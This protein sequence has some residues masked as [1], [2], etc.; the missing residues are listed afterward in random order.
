MAKDLEDKKDLVEELT[1]AEP[2]KVTVEEL[3]QAA[4]DLDAALSETTEV[5]EGEAEDPKPE[6]ETGMY[7]MIRLQIPN[8]RRISIP[9][10]TAEI[11]LTEE[12][13]P[14]VQNVTG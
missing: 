9:G 5:P 14:A 1:D 13:I 11:P 6:K 2:E 10:I 7:S 8:P 12:S 3:D 4:D